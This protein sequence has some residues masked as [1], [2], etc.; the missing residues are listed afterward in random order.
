MIPVLHMSLSR[1][2]PTTPAH[3][4]TPAQTTVVRCVIYHTPDFLCIWH[5]E[6]MQEFME[7]HVQ[8]RG[9]ET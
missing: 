1:A 2:L 3:P 7:L 5:A 6:H 4:T 9:E 8:R